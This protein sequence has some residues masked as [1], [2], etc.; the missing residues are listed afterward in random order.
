M[1]EPVRRLL[2]LH[3]KVSSALTREASYQGAL[4]IT[5]LERLR[6][7]TVDPAGDLQVELQLRR[8]KTRVPKLE[9]RVRGALSVT[10]QRC[11]RPFQWP[12][13]TAIDLRLVFNEEEESRVL[14]DSEPL[15]IEDDQVLFHAVVEEEVLLALPYAPRCEREDCEPG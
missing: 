4:P 11:L 15:L 7:V 8:D 1:N 9:G 3:A 12:L 14:K 6:A 2:P 10:C 13:D 5:R